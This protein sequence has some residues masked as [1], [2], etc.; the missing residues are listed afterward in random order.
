VPEGLRGLLERDGRDSPTHAAPSENT[1]RTLPPRMPAVRSRSNVRKRQRVRAMLT[2]AVAPLPRAPGCRHR[3]AAAPTPVTRPLGPR[4]ARA[5]R[6]LTPLASRHLGAAIPSAVIKLKLAWLLL[7]RRRREMAAAGA[8]ALRRLGVLLLPFLA[9]AACL[10]V[11]S[12]GNAPTNNPVMTLLTELKSK[13]RSG[14]FLARVA[15]TSSLIWLPST[16]ALVR[17]TVTT[18]TISLGM[19]SSGFAYLE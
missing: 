13:R 6:H 18:E 1:V 10:D 5:R 7:A 12:H 8:A 2:G 19:E 14:P 16:S 17:S 11:P 9:V 15:I 4:R 3:Q